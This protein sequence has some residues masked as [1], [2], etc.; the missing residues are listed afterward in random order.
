MVG[1]RIGGIPELIRPG[2]TGELFPAGDVDALVRAIQQVG[3]AEAASGAYSRNC[4]A[5]DF[6]TA[7]SYY[8][9]LMTLYRAAE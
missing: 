9:R 1:A 3:A 6:E 5:A 2:Q 8:D 4:S 7:Q